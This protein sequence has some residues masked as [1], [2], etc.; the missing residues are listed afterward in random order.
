MTS[1][2]AVLTY[3]RVKALESIVTGLDLHCS[4]YR[5]A[6]FDDHSSKDATAAV[7]QVNRLE[8]PVY[9]HD[10]LADRFRSRLTKN[11]PTDPPVWDVFLGSRNLGVASASNKAIRWFM[12]ETDADHLCLCNDDLTINGDFVKFYAAGHEKLRMHLFCFCD[13][14]S[15]TYKWAPI[16]VKAAD[17]TDWNLKLLPRMTGIMMS[18]TRELVNRIGYYDV[19]FGKF[20][21][22][23]CDYTNR[24]RFSGAMRLQDRDLHCIDLDTGTP[25]LLQHLEIESSVKPLDKPTFDNAARIAMAKA[26]K[27]YFFTA[28]HR[29][30]ALYQ[31]KYAG[32]YEAGGI[33]VSEMRG[34]PLV[35]Q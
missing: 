1:A 29:P 2:V 12:E 26:S 5:R 34:Y 22:E 21:E 31:P 23:H 10:W 19:S 7:L 24:A 25:P 18:I 28:W 15:E 27:L 33:T 3:N 6:I 32:A 4:A 30:Y 11:G 20:G 17:G 16:R 8:T 13:F 9:H 35:I 14:T